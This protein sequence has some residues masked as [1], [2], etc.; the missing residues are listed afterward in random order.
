MSFLTPRG[1]THLDQAQLAAILRF[2]LLPTNAIRQQ[3]D[4]KALLLCI[5]ADAPSR[6]WP[7]PLAENLRTR[8]G[9]KTPNRFTRRCRYLDRVKI[10]SEGCTLTIGVSF[11]QPFHFVWTWNRKFGTFLSKYSKN[12]RIFGFRS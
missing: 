12:S 10:E 9:V 3:L 5:N 6:R 1:R 2:S 11:Y 4:Y 8:Q 7:F